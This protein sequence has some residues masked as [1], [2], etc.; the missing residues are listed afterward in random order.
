MPMKTTEDFALGD[1]A[2]QFCSHCTDD[3]GKLKSYEEILAGTANYLAY[4]Q[5]IDPAAAYNVANQML[6]ELPAW[7]K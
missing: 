5:G 1:S 4:S 7:K 2:Q 6:S 3:N